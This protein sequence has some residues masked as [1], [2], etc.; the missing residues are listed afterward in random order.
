MGYCKSCDKHWSSASQAHCSACHE[1][2]RSVHAFDKHR[3]GQGQDRRCM[4][5]DEMLKAEMVHTGAFWV[6]ARFEAGTA[7]GLFHTKE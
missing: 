7:I 6:S 4:S 2:F 3:I 5:I 1:H